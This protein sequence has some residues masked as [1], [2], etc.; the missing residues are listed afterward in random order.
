MGFLCVLILLF[1]PLF[2]LIMML[3]FIGL[4]V[5]YPCCRRG[6]HHGIYDP[7]DK[8]ISGVATCYLSMLACCI[9]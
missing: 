6:Y 2:S 4:V 8:A 9:G 3:V 1:F 5:I 7:F